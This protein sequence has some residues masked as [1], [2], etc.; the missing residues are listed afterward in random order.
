MFLKPA[1]GATLGAL[2]SGACAALECSPLAIGKP[3][4]LGA[5]II[6]VH[7]HET[8]NYTTYGTG[9]GTNDGGLQTISFCN[10]TVI[11]THPGWNDTVTTQVWL[12]LENWN[13][14]FQGLG[15]G[16]YSTGID[17]VYLPYAV[18]QGY[19]SAS[20]DGGHAGGVITAT[21]DLSWALS[22][23]NN[24]NWFLLENYASKATNDMAEI[25][26]QVIEAYYKA[27]PR[28]SY[29]NGCSGGG[30]QA[31][32]MAQ[33]FPGAFDGILAVAPAINIETFIPAGYWPSQVMN[34]DNIS[35][36]ACEVEGFTQAAVRA[37]DALDG[38]GDSTI[39][40][41][42]KCKVSAR[43]FVGQKYNCNGTEYTLTVSGAKAVQAAWSGS[44]VSGYYGLNKDADLTSFYIPT[45]SNAVDG[46][47]F[48]GGD[49]F[50][51][52]IVYLAAKDPHFSVSDMTNAEFFDAI[53]YSQATYASM[54]A[55]NS[56]DLSAFKAAGGK[57]IAW[58][59]LADEAIPPKGIVSYYGEVLKK[60]RRAHD[61]FRFFEAPGVGHCS[62]GL[63]PVP[64]AALDQLV[65]WV[66]NGAAPDTLRAD[67]GSNGTERNLCQYP[68]QQVYVGGDPS[69]PASFTCK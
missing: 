1:I 38:V 53:R 66:E 39:S 31:L 12:P 9:P 20:T 22:S 41:P 6:D 14:R 45:G 69:K 37:C 18:A 46:I 34:R 63:G 43:D 2:L 30:R 33:A 59:G 3:K 15:G 13:G 57:M 24:V 4:L 44:G 23:T 29:F 40:L 7:A 58:H 55:T 21:L 16:G 50:P 5:S 32:A 49:L 17:S 47:E 19:A 60:D 35:L 25:G 27:P 62:G 48:W 36:S 11:Y 68:L 51:N 56:P 65:E 28:Y 54:L 42:S 26:K 61:F 52:W 67:R 10:V 64:N 8:H